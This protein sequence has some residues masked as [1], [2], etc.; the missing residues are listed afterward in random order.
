MRFNR[1]RNLFSGGVIS[2]MNCGMN[3]G[4]AI[5]NVFILAYALDVESVM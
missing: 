5:K 1:C 4:F 3:V 2:I